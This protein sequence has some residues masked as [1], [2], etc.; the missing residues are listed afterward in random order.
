MFTQEETRSYLQSNGIV[1]LTELR[2]MERMEECPSYYF[3]RKYWKSFENYR[4]SIGFTIV[5][6]LI[7]LTLKSA[8]YPH[9]NS[10]IWQWKSQI[11]MHQ[12]EL[13]MKK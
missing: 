12:E 5:Q 7:L 3:I 9:Y 8:V 1:S 2:K 13:Y 6:H 10:V 11:K 4:K